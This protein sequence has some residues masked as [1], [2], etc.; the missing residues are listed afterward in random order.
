MYLEICLIIL[1]IAFVLLVIFCI[2]ILLQIWL[3][4][5]NI[6]VTLEILNQRLP[7]ILKN[8]EEI[9]TNINSSTAA[10]NKEI[11]NVS[12][13]VDRFH[14]VVDNIVDDIKNIAPL[15]GKFSFFQ[16][17]K[18]TIAIVKGVRVF[19]DVFLHKK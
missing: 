18:N 10:V 12:N 11:Q 9:T 16:M 3:T 2:P 8:L 19:M 13:T 4:S 6:T 17:I 5:K 14:L 15:A 1:G 7:A